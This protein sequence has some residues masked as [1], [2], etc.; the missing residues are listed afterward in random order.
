V[1]TSPLPIQHGKLEDTAV[2]WGTVLYEGRQALIVASTD[3]SGKTKVS[4]DTG[5]RS[6]ELQTAPKDDEPLP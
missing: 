1:E 5:E 3:E 6:V 4:F 2:A